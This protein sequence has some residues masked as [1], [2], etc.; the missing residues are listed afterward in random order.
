[1]KDVVLPGLAITLFSAAT[2]RTDRIILLCDITGSGLTTLPID[3]SCYGLKLIADMPPKLLA[4][5]GVGHSSESWVNSLSK[6]FC[7]LTLESGLK[8]MDLRQKE[9]N[10]LDIQHAVKV[11]TRAGFFV[12]ITELLR[13]DLS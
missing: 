8:V 9:G 2:A 4:F 1:M 7:P 5:T 11:H 10:Y 3:V 12:P 6:Y 13:R